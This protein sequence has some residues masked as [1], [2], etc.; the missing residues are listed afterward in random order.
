MA[1]GGLGAAIVATI[2]LATNDFN[3]GLWVALGVFVALTAALIPLFYFLLFRPNTMAVAR[4]FDKLGLDERLITMLELEQDTS[5][6]AVKQREDAKAALAKTKVSALK[7]SIPLFIILSLVAGLALSVGMLAAAGTSVSHMHGWRPPSEEFYAANFANIDFRTQLAQ[8]DEAN[9]VNTVPGF[10]SG[11]S[12]QTVAIG[13]T[14]TEVVATGI[15]LHAFAVWSDHWEI[16]KPQIELP[17]GTI[18]GEPLENIDQLPLILQL[19]F[20]LEQNRIAIS[21]SSPARVI[22]DIESDQV[23]YAIFI[24]VNP[25]ADPSEFPPEIVEPPL[26]P[27]PEELD[28][29]DEILGD[30]NLQQRLQDSLRLLNNQLAHDSALSPQQRAEIQNYINFINSI[31]GDNRR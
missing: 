9:P 20:A 3:I 24:P 19:A 29:N 4:R 5:Y 27:D 11:D 6:I 13:G 23:I 7:L 10:I 2:S 18:N 12:F 16:I 8:R 28:L 31:L 25:P 30:T 14:T 22:T 1:G 15:G 26:P 21:Q 17:E